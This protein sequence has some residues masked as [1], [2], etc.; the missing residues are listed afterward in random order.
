MVRGGSSLQGGNV[1]SMFSSSGNISFMYF[2]DLYSHTSFSV[3]AK[4]DILHSYTVPAVSRFKP[5]TTSRRVMTP[6][7]Y[8][9][10]L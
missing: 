9:I 1:G 8:G 2:H 6:T 4:W 10:D 7:Q 5:A 3:L